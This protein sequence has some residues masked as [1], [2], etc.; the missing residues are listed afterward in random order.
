MK[1]KILQDSLNLLN[2]KFIGLQK[3]SGSNDIWLGI[4][5]IEFALIIYLLFRRGAKKTAKENYKKEAL[6]T[7]IDFENIIDSSF[8]SLKLYNEL[9]VRCHPDK[10]ID[11]KEKNKIALLIFQELTKNKG[12]LKKLEE[13]KSEAINKLDIKI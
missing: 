8:N 12:N 3:S 10:F 9:K 1:E 6:S 7:T 4:T 2:Q 5:L 11:D 13:L